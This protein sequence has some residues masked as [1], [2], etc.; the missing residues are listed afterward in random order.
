MI[1]FCGIF[2]LDGGKKQLEKIV[3]VYKADTTLHSAELDDMILGEAVEEISIMHSNRTVLSVLFAIYLAVSVTASLVIHKTVAKPAKKAGETINSMIEKLENNEGDLTERVPVTTKDE[4][5]QLANGINAFI[6]SL[7]MT[8]IQIQKQSVSL[9]KTVEAMS[10]HIENSNE[11]AGNVSAVMQ[12]LSARMEE[13][14]ASLSQI[15]TGAQEVLGAA[16]FI[17][18]EVEQGNGF[19][20][21]VKNRAVDVNSYV[22]ESKVNTNQ[23]ISEIGGQ[24]ESAIENS[25]SVN[26]INALTGE[27]LNISSQTNL[28]A[29]NASIEAARAGEAG[30]GFAVVADEIRVL[31]DS[32]RETANNI[33]VISKNVTEAVEELAKNAGDMIEYINGHVLTDYDTFENIAGQYHKDAENM[34]Y[35]LSQFLESSENLK[36]VMD[37]MVVSIDGISGAIEESTQS[38]STAADS[39]GMLVLA[40]QD[41]SREAQD[42]RKVS[43]K[44]RKEVEKFK[45]I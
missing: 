21:Q 33:Q 12:E 25:K 29:L 28:L 22:K 38:T 32:S 1:G 15:T 20:D 2:S 10:G 13:V 19:V 11:N 18:D 9:D 42:N 23:M 27:I 43:G 41:I 31:A 8:I 16:Q 17:K 4:V 45:R 44:L 7:Q 40:M 5:G 3:A 36:G 14:S 35:M 37:H 30:R 24:L 6:E 34:A 26:Q 39:A